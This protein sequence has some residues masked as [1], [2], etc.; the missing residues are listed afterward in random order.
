MPLTRLMQILI[1]DSL[2][3]FN[4]PLNRCRGQCYDGASGKHTGVCT[5]IQKKEPRAMYIHCMGHSLNLA[6]QNTCRSIQVMSAAFD[7][8]IKNIQ[9]QC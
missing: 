3:R 6:V 8:A 4:L 5:Q 9:I 1:I 7:V 2:I